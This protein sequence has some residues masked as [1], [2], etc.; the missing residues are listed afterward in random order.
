MALLQIQRTL[1]RWGSRTLSTLISIGG[2]PIKS[3]KFYE[4]NPY[5]DETDFTA[6]CMPISYKLAGQ[7]AQVS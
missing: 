3:A 7:A 1:H 5:F 6:G 2:Q 4:W